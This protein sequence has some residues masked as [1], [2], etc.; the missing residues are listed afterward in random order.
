MTMDK[1]IRF[2]ELAV[3][4]ADMLPAREA[5][6]LINW[7]NVQLSQTVLALNAVTSHSV[8]QALGSQTIS[9]TQS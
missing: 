3:E 1:E 4:Q 9:I 2:E 6:A 8:A 7:A 5:L